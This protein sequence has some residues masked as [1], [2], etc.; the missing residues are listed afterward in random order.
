MVE[1]FMSGKRAGAIVEAE[2]NHCTYKIIA[3]VR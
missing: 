3:G 1:E 2:V